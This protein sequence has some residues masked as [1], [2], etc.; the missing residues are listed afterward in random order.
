M[1]ETQPETHT[2]SPWLQLLR[3]AYAIPKIVAVGNVEAA[4]AARMTREYVAT[5]QRSTGVAPPLGDQQMGFRL[6][7]LAAVSTVRRLGDAGLLDSWFADLG[8]EQPAFSNPLGVLAEAITHLAMLPLD[9][10]KAMAETLLGKVLPKEQPNPPEG[11]NA[12]V[13]G[14]HPLV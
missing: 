10:G 1:M 13:G 8:N 7:A 12:A 14:V 11:Q 5:H 4:V 3:E 6:V 9:P 2:H